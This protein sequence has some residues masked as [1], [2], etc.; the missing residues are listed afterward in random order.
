MSIG[1]QITLII[2]LTLIALLWILG[3]YFSDSNNNKKK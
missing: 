1:V 3:K 2:C